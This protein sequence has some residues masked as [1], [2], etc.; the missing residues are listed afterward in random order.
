MIL[1]RLAGEQIVIGD[2]ITITVVEI[3]GGKVRLGFKAPKDVRID[4]SE[5]RER[6]TRDGL[7]PP[8]AEPEGAD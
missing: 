7:R 4:R 5:V 1:S 3:Q 2:S 6:I 8:R